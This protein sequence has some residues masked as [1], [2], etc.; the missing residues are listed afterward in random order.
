[1]GIRS[2]CNSVRLEKGWL[3]NRF[4]AVW[5]TIVITAHLTVPAIVVLI[6]KV[7]IVYLVICLLIRGI[8]GILR[9]TPA[10]LF[11]R[12]SN[13]EVITLWYSGQPAVLVVL[14][15]NLRDGSAQVGLLRPR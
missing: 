4:A 5:Y 11:G 3:G 13:C 10:D 14:P 15:H 1:M 2:F 7:S 12:K 6:L 8:L 9:R